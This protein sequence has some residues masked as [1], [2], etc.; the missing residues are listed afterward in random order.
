MSGLPGVRH[1]G[2][3]GLPVSLRA[4]LA[5]EFHTT[6]AESRS[7]GMPPSIPLGSPDQWRSVPPFQRPDD[8]SG[9][10]CPK[11]ADR[12]RSR[13]NAVSACWLC[14]ANKARYAPALTT[15]TNPHRTSGFQGGTALET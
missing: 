11:S 4:L 5:K 8:V 9:V 13:A 6:S 1:A 14:D 15:P 12:K 3:T 10:D 7:V 2:H